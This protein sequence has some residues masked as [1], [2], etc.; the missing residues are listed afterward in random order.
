MGAISLQEK[1]N[2]FERDKSS[3]LCHLRPYNFKLSDSC[4]IKP[5]ED[6]KASEGSP[7][8]CH[9]RLGAGSQRC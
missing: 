9:W 4:G 2:Q 7:G 5:Q 3:M 1:K 6:N 8:E